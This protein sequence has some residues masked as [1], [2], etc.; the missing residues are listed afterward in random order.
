MFSS[1]TFKGYEHEL[2]ICVTV[3]HDKPALRNTTIEILQSRGTATSK[4]YNH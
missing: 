4:L 2:E 3:T 1:E